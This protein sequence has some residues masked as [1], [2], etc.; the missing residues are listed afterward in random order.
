[1]LDDH[2]RSESSLNDSRF[3]CS[4][5]LVFLLSGWQAQAETADHVTSF[6]SNAADQLVV[7]C[8]RCL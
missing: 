5:S 7:L 4:F 6:S 1:M 3:E 8:T 2:E